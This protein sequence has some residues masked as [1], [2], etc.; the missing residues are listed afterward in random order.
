MVAREGV[1]PPTTSL[2]SAGLY[3]SLNN[4][5]DFRWPPKYLRSRER[6]ANRGWKSWV[7]TAILEFGPIVHSCYATICCSP[8]VRTF[9][10]NI[11]QDRKCREGIRPT[12]IEGQVRDHLRSLCLCQ[13]VVH[14]SIEVVR[15]LRNLARSNQRAHSHQAPI[16]RRKV[17]TQPQVA[18]QNVSGV[19]HDALSDTTELLFNVRCAFRFRLLIEGKRRRRSC[20]KLIVPNLT[21]GKDNFRDGDCRHRILPARVKSEM[22]DDLRNLAWLHAIIKCKVEIVG[23]FNRLVARD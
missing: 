7:Q 9:L 5:S 6:H 18:E 13:A 17:R 1:D 14:R 15:D 2:F 16:S 4:L 19:L 11:L 21:I 3:C 22:R 23:Y 20:R 12:G 8:L 10:E